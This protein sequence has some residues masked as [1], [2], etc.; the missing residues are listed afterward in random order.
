MKKSLQK[1]GDIFLTDFESGYRFRVRVGVR[2]VLIIQNNVGNY[3]SN[4][5]IVA[6]ITSNTL[7]HNLP[8]HMIISKK[9][10]LLKNSIVMGEQLRTLD[11]SRILK[12]VGTLRNKDVIKLNL[13]LKA[14]LGL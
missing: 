10:G 9:Y 12:Y 7:K 3:Y 8:T 1:K 2:P 4:T 14:S 5:V 11:K 6:I 13:I